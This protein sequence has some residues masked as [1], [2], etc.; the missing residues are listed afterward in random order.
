LAGS[1]AAAS[2]RLAI[3]T[4]EAAGQV[5]AAAWV[6]LLQDGVF[7]SLWG[8]PTLTNSGKCYESGEF[9]R[10][11]DHGSSGVAGNGEKIRCEDNNG[12]RWEPV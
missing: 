3:F 11:S 2:D 6:A 12:W 1:L 4:A 10:K 5:V 8:G 9:C 7:A